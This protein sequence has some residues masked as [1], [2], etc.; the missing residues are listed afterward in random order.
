MKIRRFYEAESQSPEQLQ[1]SNETLD[2][3]MDKLTEISQSFDSK[4]KEITTITDTLSN[5]L[6]SSKSTNNQIDDAHLNLETIKTKIKDILGLMD[7][8]NSQLK[9]YYDSGERFIY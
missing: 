4:T 2:E 9:D 5:F 3:M 6:S 1:L 8:V 7:Q